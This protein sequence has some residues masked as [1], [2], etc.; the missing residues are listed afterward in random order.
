MN[1]VPWKTWPAGGVGLG[2]LSQDQGEGDAN[3]LEILGALLCTLLGLAPRVKFCWDFLRR[4]DPTTM[5]KKWQVLPTFGGK[6]RIDD[7]LWLFGQVSLSSQFPNIFLDQI[8]YQVSLERLGRLEAPRL[9]EIGAKT[10]QQFGMLDVGIGNLDS[11][12]VEIVVFGS[13]KIG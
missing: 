8:H 5:K 9:F 2:G 6:F 12:V 7:F 3:V 4:N 11:T 1:Q 13:E 10:Q